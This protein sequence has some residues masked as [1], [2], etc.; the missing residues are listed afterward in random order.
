MYGDD[1][2][3]VM[4]IKYVDTSNLNGTGNPSFKPTNIPNW[5]I[6]PTKWFAMGTIT[7]LDYTHIIEYLT[8][9]NIIY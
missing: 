8:D 5:F 2:D 6:I 3:I 1:V 7:D 4:M 9:Y